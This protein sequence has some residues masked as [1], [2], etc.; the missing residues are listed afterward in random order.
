MSVPYASTAP[1]PYNQNYA[2][3]PTFQQPMKQA[4][5]PQVN[6]VLAQVKIKLSLIFLIFFFSP[7]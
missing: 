4:N 7:S 5:P 6:P 1:T 2:T 3:S